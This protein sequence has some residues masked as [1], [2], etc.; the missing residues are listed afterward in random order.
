MIKYL[1]V[2]SYISL[3]RSMAMKPI[4]NRKDHI[5]MHYEDD[6]HSSM[7]SAERAAIYVRLSKEDYDKQG[8]EESESI[9][10]QKTLLIEYAFSQKWDIQYIY[11][12]DDRKGTDKDRPDFNRMLRDAQRKKF[13]IILCK[14]QSRFSR[15]LEI[16][17][18]YLH[19]LF[20][21]WGIR[22]VSIVDNVDTFV[23]GNKKTR[24][25][26]G[27]TNEWYLEDLSDNIRSVFDVKRKK[28]EYI[29]SWALYGYVKDPENKNRL[30]LDEE[31]AAVVREIY[32]LYLL[33]NGCQRI[34]KLLN[35]RGISNPYT[36]KKQ[37]GERINP[38]NLTKK[39]AYW[40][41]GTVYNILKNRTYTGDLVQGRFKKASYKSKKLLRTSPEEWIVCEGTHEPIIE[42]DKF[43]KVQSLLQSKAKPTLSGKVH[44]LSKKVRCLE[45]GEY[46]TLSG[47][48]VNSRNE[49]VRYLGCSNRRV[50]KENCIGASIVYHNLEKYILDQ[51]NK[52]TA[53]YFD[54]DTVEN[55]IRF[56]DTQ[57]EQMAIHSS[58]FLESLKKLEVREEAVKNLYLDKVKGI[59]SDDQFMSLNS[60]FTN[61]IED[62]KKQIQ[63]Q[64]ETI[65]RFKNAMTETKNKES[66]ISKYRNVTR[67]SRE[68]VTELIDTIYVGHKDKKTKERII[69]IIWNF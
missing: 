65:D 67:L 51:I 53:L 63:F 39:S 61:D 50:N 10:N 59:I 24:Q 62:I 28:G 26:L 48:S 23:R 35:Q 64:K 44:V 40:A 13:S 33:G 34:S 18:K 60:Q 22:F 29:G 41:T 32:N 11:V 17:E 58:I 36:Y 68:V 55:Q 2:G 52:M 5:E 30:V 7:K 6:N 27:L 69:K 38:P 31:A 47:V 3:L 15:E 37:K 1:Q 9:Q 42:K 46:L 14:S 54:S 56:Q 57:A 25:I 43:W 12:D 16:I 20:I 19:G 45:C 49:P 8:F 66:I 4:I 21:E